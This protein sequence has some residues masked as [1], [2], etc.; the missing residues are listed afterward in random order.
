MVQGLAQALAHCELAPG[1]AGC[2]L[3]HALEARAR[4]SRNR[5]TSPA[6]HLQ[7][8][9]QRL[10]HAQVIGD[11][12][13]ARYEQGMSKYLLGQYRDRV[14]QNIEMVYQKVVKKA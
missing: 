5:Q 2:L 9:P 8:P 13:A 7:D 12:L 10:N 3:H 6:H 1:V 14:G 11:Q 4:R